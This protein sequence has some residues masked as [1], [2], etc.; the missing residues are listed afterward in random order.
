MNNNHLPDYSV[1]LDEEKVTFINKNHEK[2]DQW[3][4]PEFDTK[5]QYPKL[6][7]RTYDLAR[8]VA[9][10]Y[11]VY[12]LEQEWQNF[13]YR[14]VRKRV[15]NLDGAFIAFCKKLYEQNPNP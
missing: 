5:T 7:Q 4:N 10:G 15:K 9:P 6:N 2:M 12:Y 13:W 1:S 11:D 14:S 3:C 8:K